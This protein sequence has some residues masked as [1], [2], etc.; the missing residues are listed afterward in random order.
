VSEGTNRNLPTSNT[1]AL[2][3]D[4]ESHNLQR[5]RQTDRRTDDTMMPI[6]D[7]YCVAVGLRSAINQNNYRSTRDDPVQRLTRL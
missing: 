5:Y 4:H 2:Y 7:T 1:L 3:T 6:V